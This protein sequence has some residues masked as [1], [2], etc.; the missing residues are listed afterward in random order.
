MVKEHNFKAKEV[1]IN[2]VHETFEILN[3]E[4]NLQ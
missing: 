3:I 1:S 2:N 4:L